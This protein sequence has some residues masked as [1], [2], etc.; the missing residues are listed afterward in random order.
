MKNNRTNEKS[1]KLFRF[2]EQFHTRDRKVKKLVIG[3]GQQ[4][5]FI[6]LIFIPIMSQICDFQIFLKKDIDKAKQECQKG[7]VW[8]FFE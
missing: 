6:I 1:D 7:T 8:L 5:D 2:Q 3:F 4:T